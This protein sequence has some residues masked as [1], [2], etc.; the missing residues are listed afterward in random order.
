MKKVRILTI[1]FAIAVMLAVTLFSSTGAAHAATRQ[2]HSSLS[3]STTS[4]GLFTVAFSY[5]PAAL[6]ITRSD[7][8]NFYVTVQQ[9]Q[10]Y[11]QPIGYV[12]AWLKLP[13]Q[14]SWSLVVN[15]SV[16]TLVPVSINDFSIVMSAT[17]L[18]PVLSINTCEWS[19]QFTHF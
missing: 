13:N 8:V 6:R 4:C 1:T 2:A 12:Y 19:V 11:F 3:S 18:E 15:S 14:N 17:L 9:I 16:G 10:Y 5:Y 7:G